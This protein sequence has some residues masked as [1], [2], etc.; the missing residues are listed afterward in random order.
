[1]SYNR[2]ISKPQAKS[3]IPKD[4]S[5]IRQPARNVFNRVNLN[6][7]QS[8]SQHSNT[9]DIP[10]NKQ[11]LTRVLNIDKLL[12]NELK[13]ISIDKCNLFEDKNFPCTNESLSNDF[14]NDSNIEWL[15]PEE[16]N[17][18]YSLEFDDNNN[19]SQ[20]LQQQLGDCWFI[21]ACYSLFSQMGSRFYRRV[22]IE[23]SSGQMK[24]QFFAN[25]ASNRIDKFI[26]ISIDDRL[27]VKQQ[28]KKLIYGCCLDTTQFWFPLLEKAYVKLYGSNYENIVAGIPEEAFIDLCGAFTLYLNPQNSLDHETIRYKLMQL[29]TSNKLICCADTI[30]LKATAN[31]TSK[32]VIETKKSHSFVVTN[33]IQTQNDLMIELKNLWATSNLIFKE[34]WSLNCSNTSARRNNADCDY[35]ELSL[36]F[37]DFQTYFGAITFALH[38]PDYESLPRRKEFTEVSGSF[39]KTYSKFEILS[40]NLNLKEQFMDYLFE[41]SEFYLL[42]ARPKQNSYELLFNLTQYSNSIEREKLRLSFIEIDQNG[43][44]SYSKRVETNRVGRTISKLLSFNS[45]KPISYIIAATVIANDK[46]MGKFL[47]LNYLFRILHLELNEIQ[48][49]KLNFKLEDEHVKLDVNSCKSCKKVLLNELNEVKIHK[50]DGEYYCDE[51]FIKRRFDRNLIT[52]GNDDKTSQSNRNYRGP[53]MNATGGFKALMLDYESLM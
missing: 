44:G 31:K 8:T 27:P 22:F 35:S 48:I 41:A 42:E 28:N 39:K 1:M 5:P 16:I 24:F 29:K 50:V 12:A 19:G 40:K 26:K 38:V 7:D 37:K 52:R 33:V 11:I 49:R 51:C 6:K 3:T 13:D 32:I 46:E 9:S 23:K 4:A 18:T 14:Q 10:V 34:L 30:P 15:R 2:N 25:G 43:V 20:P 45:E 47:S 53:S 17:E 36:K 21:C